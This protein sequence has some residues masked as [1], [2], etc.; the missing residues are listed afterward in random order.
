MLAP[1]RHILPLTTIRRE[2]L[3]PRNGKI[4]VRKGQSVSPFDPIGEM[5]PLPEHFMLDVAHGLGIAPAQADGCIQCKPGMDLAE[6]DL[7]AEHSKWARRIVRSP[8]NGRVVLVANGQVLIEIK[9]QPEELLAGFPGSVEELIPDRGAILET[10]GALIQGVWGNY[11]M[12]FGMLRCL[13]SR[14]DE[15]LTAANLDVSLRGSVVVGGH[16]QDGDT[17]RAASELPLKGL[18]LASM[19]VDLIKPAGASQIPILVL[20]GFGR[21]PMNSSA[22]KLLGT[23]D[24]REAAVMAQPWDLYTGVRPEIIIPLPAPS[25]T[26]RPPETAEFRE[27]QMVRLAR[28]PGLGKIGVIIGLTGVIKL[29]NGVRTQA[30]E[31]RL[32]NGEISRVP[33]ANLE[34]LE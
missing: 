20:E 25:E 9:R 14:P 26:G 27:G 11:H 16:C 5:R 8:V 12:D 30:A 7:I 23:N 21:L 28:H 18:V 31:I 15:V 32:E 17:L 2:R 3:L 1:V 4:L 24:K 13:A 29:L 10:S 34:V 33:L 19:A 6:D 22:Y